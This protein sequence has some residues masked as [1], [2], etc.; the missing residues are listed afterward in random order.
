[1]LSSSGSRA[2]RLA[3]ASM[4][5]LSQ[6]AASTTRATGST[7]TDFTLACVR[8]AAAQVPARGLRWSS[9]ARAADNDDDK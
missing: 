1:M 7:S 4:R 9:A 6:L 2:G 3:L 8:N 5:A